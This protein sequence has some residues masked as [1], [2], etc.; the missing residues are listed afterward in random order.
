MMFEFFG[1]SKLVRHLLSIMQYHPS[2]EPYE[3]L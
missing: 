2:Y 1:A 3:S